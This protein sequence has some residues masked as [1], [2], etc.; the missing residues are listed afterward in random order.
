MYLSGNISSR[1]NKIWHGINSLTLNRLLQEKNSSKYAIIISCNKQLLKSNWRNDQK[2]W[3][4]FLFLEILTATHKRISQCSLGFSK[5]WGI[6]SFAIK[7]VTRWCIVP[8][9]LTTVAGLRGIQPALADQMNTCTPED[10]IRQRFQ[11][12]PRMVRAILLSQ[13]RLLRA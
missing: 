1:I 7:L 5:V 9:F 3:Y 4:Q 11:G 13:A 10:P 6:Y 2:L 8:A 12:I